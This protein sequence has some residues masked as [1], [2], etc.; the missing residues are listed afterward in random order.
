MSYEIAHTYETV[1]VYR[2]GAAARIELNRPE[3]MNAWNEQFG[4]DMLA[5]LGS[6]S[7]DPEVRALELGGAGRGF[8]SGAD[9]KGGFEPAEDGYPDPRRMLKTYYHPIILAV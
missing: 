4:K 5:A 2:D 8:S 7:D 6:V 1:N 9:L 3:S